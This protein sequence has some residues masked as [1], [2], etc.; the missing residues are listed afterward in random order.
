MA[1]DFEITALHWE[2]QSGGRS[3]GS[4]ERRHRRELRMRALFSAL[5]TGPIDAAR[6]AFT[7]L[8]SSDADLAHNASLGRIGAALQSSNLALALRLA[9]E[10]QADNPKA[11]K[12]FGLPTRAS[13]NGTKVPAKTGFV[14]GFTGRFF[15]VSA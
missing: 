10:M 15:D 14:G 8:I 4:D 12:G 2:T 9:I 7:A 6:L 5:Q 13:D 1:H 11:F 3:D